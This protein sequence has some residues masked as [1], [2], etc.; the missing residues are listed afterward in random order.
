MKWKRGSTLKLSDCDFELPEELI[1][2][3]PLPHRD[4]SRLMV[5]PRG[6]GL[7]HGTFRDIVDLLQP[8][9]LLV[10]NDA[11]VVPARLL[12]QKVA[13][14]GK[15][16]LLLSMPLA[17]GD[18]WRCI[19]QAS[20]PIREG[21]RLR[22]DE[23]EAEVLAAH[24]EGV[25]DVRF[26]ADDLFG[27]LERVGRIPLPPYIRRDPSEADKQRYQTV[28][29]KTPGAV[30]APTAG[31]H[32]TPELLEQLRAKG[33][34]LAEVTLYVGPGTFL[35]IR[36]DDVESHVM[37]AEFFRV[38]AEAAQAVNEAKQRGGRVIPVGTTALR[39]LESAADEQGVVRAGEGESRLFVYP[40]YHFK[41]VDALVTNFHLPRSTLLL[42]VSALAGRERM[43]DAYREAV[44]QRYRFFS[45]GDAMFIA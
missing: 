6:G 19:G 2:Q 34:R 23:L 8:D 15:V 25:Y 10:L 39:T 35:P 22:F 12:G 3:E 9:D 1:A 44:L 5:L 30:A 16:E 21:M 24:G 43:L 33:V 32:F 37:H 40:G 36:G 4:Q 18:T 7:E 38:S 26:H 13:T 45:Y 29:A 17:G 27:A 14:G 28:Y 41:A 11:R 42:L 31:L 20:K